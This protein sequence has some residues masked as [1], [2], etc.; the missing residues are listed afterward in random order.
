MKMALN[1]VQIIN[2]IYQA[3]SAK[4][5]G[6]EDFGLKRENENKF[7]NVET[8]DGFGVT[9][10]GNKLMIKYASEEPI[11]VMHDKRFEYKLEQRINDI[12]NTIVKNFSSV[13]GT[14]LKLKQ[15][16]EL[17]SLVET[18]NRVRVK[19]KAQMAYEVGNLSEVAEVSQSSEERA[20]KTVEVNAAAKKLEKGKVKPVNVT[21]KDK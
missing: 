9:L 14:S 10:H 18:T 3:I 7:V 16:G 1:V 19:V 4:H 8:M 2:G 21:R 17:V 6:G 20:A 5:Q 13:T 11:Q 12:K 15:Q